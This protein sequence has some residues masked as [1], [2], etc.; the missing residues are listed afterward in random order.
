MPLNSLDESSAGRMLIYIANHLAHKPSTELQIYQKRDLESTFIEIINPKMSNI[1]IGCI[2]RHGNMGLNDFNNEYLNPRLSKLKKAVLLLGDYNVEKN[3][4]SS[5]L[6]LSNY[7]NESTSDRLKKANV[8]NK[9]F[10]SIEE[11][12]SIK[13]KVLK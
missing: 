13:N 9:Y 12:N 5:L 6:I 1:F 4:T 3:S 2:C 8:F 11:K 10:C 7:N